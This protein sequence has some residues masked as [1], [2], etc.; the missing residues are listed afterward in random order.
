ML[1]SN[2]SA[3]SGLREAMPDGVAFFIKNYCV[4]GGR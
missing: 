4:K 2:P 1:K 3:K